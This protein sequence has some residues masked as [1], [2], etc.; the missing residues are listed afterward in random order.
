MWAA[1]R[2]ATSTLVS[3][4]GFSGSPVFASTGIVRSI[5]GALKH[6]DKPPLFLMGL[7]HGHFPLK[8]D[9]ATIVETD[10]EP[11]QMQARDEINT[12]IAIVVPIAQILEVLNQPRIKEAE[13]AVIE[14]TQAHLRTSGVDQILGTRPSRAASPCRFLALIRRRA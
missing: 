2:T 4:G 11:D 3:V 7:I 13:Q 8:Q 5:D 14:E 10:V 6:Y 12:G 1:N 9:A